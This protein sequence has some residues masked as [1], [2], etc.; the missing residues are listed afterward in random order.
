MRQK[1]LTGLVVCRIFTNFWKLHQ[2][3][4]VQFLF[5]ILHSE[6]FVVVLEQEMGEPIC[7]LKTYTTSF[8]LKRDNARIVSFSLF[9]I[10]HW[11][12]C[13][14][15]IALFKKNF[16]NSAVFNTARAHTLK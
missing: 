16:L 15:E 12:F 7:H 8:R 3:E 10:H 14:K 11:R 1:P 2:L 9:S 4:L 6:A 13:Q 5:P